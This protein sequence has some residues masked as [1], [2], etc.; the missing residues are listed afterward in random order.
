[1]NA[2]WCLQLINLGP[3]YIS[4]YI[5][6]LRHQTISYDT[7]YNNHYISQ[8]GRYTSNP[9]PT[10]NMHSLTDNSGPARS[11]NQLYCGYG[12]QC[13]VHGGKAECVCNSNCPAQSGP[14]TVCGSDGQTYGSECQLKLFACRLQKNIR[15]AYSGQCRGLLLLKKNSS[16]TSSRVV[17][18]YGRDLFFLMWLKQLLF[19]T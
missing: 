9:W 17:L 8:P 15:F 3:L 11:C 16:I 6:H 10:F 12:A 18:Y 4:L 13:E 14:T 19:Y 1:M 7:I 2:L 5:Y